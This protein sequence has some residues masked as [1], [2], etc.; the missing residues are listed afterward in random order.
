M[1]QPHKGRRVRM[2]VR[3]PYDLHA[4]ASQRAA[5]RKW[6][7]SDYVAWCVEN[8]VHPGRLA[9]QRGV[10]RAKERQDAR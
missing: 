9:A 1:P 6:N 5:A 7:M 2:T 4:E 10:E 8:A 3:L